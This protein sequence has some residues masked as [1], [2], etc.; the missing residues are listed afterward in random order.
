LKRVTRY[1]F[2][3]EFIGAD[4]LV[5]KAIT[6]FAK[7]YGR[8][9]HE[10]CAKKGFAPKLLSYEEIPGGWIF[11]LMENVELES[12]SRMDHIEKRLQ[13]NRILQDLHSENF[14]HGDLRHTNVFWNR[15]ENKVI[16]IDFDWSGRNGI[17]CY[18]SDMNPE[19]KWP[20]GAS[21]GKFLSFDHDVFWINQLLE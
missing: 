3:V 10:Y 9:V 2:L 8:E 4:G 5:Y 15:A 12:I 13:L 14:V 1:V 18:P 19:I 11:I 7:H 21:T 16:L 20:E 17:K 6:K